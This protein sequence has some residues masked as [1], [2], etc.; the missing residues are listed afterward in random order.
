[1][2]K[3]GR[4]ETQYRGASLVVEAGPDEAALFINGIRRAQASTAG[5]EVIRLNSS[6]QTDYEW[7]EFIEAVV[8]LGSDGRG[9]DVVISAS[10][11]E[12]VTATLS[13]P[14]I[15]S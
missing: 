2:D 4:V 14:E 6:V 3:M 5:R 13:F 9:C 12:V 15:A 8:T 7:H 1:M 11:T 10:N